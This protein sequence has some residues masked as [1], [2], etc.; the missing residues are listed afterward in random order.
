VPVRELWRYPVKALGGERVA[1]ARMLLRGV[2]G[3]RCHGLLDRAGIPVTAR[4]APGLV[5]FAASWEPDA[6]PLVRAP[7]GGVH[8]WFDDPL[9]DLLVEVAGPCRPYTVPAGAFDA[10]PVLL[11]GTRSVDEL[12]RML[13]RPLDPRRFRANLLCDLPEAFAEDDWIGRVVV[14]G[15]AILRVLERCSRC[16]VASVDPDTAEPTPDVLELVRHERDGCLGVYCE[17]LTPGRVA[18]GAGVNA[19]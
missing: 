13:G 10:W 15:D 18:E 5:R 14:V 9:R 11:L 12:G 4:E 3:D 7:D 8:R 6:A 19:G 1:A 17:V 16:V 2:E